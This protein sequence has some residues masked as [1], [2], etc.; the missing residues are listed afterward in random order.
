M[1]VS[2][3]MSVHDLQP[4]SEAWERCWDSIL[5][6][7]TEPLDLDLL[8]KKAERVVR[9]CRLSAGDD[10]IDWFLWQVQDGQLFVGEQLVADP[11]SVEWLRIHTALSGA[12]AGVTGEISTAS[13]ETV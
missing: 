9:V 7:P 4:A 2:N 11:D 10:G 13:L 8:Y 6:L 12:H 1:I 5:R 3:T